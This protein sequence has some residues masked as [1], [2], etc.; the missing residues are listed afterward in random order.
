KTDVVPLR[1]FHRSSHQPQSPSSFAVGILA[2]LDSSHLPE[3]SGFSYRGSNTHRRHLS[4]GSHGFLYAAKY[5]PI[6]RFDIRFFHLLLSSKIPGL[7]PGRARR[8]TLLPRFHFGLDSEQNR[9][10]GR[11]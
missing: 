8:R 3:K 2:P 4:V 6:D 9:L 5:T 7:S 11:R 1:K 10:N